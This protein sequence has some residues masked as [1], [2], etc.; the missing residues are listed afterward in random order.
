MS[1]STQGPTE[2]SSASPRTCRRAAA[3]L[4]PTAPIRSATSSSGAPASLGAFPTATVS[5]VSVRR[6]SLSNGILASPPASPPS[7]PRRPAAP[8]PRPGPRLHR[9]QQGGPGATK[10]GRHVG[11]RLGPLAY[12]PHPIREVQEH[13][14][15]RPKRAGRGPHRHAQA[16]HRL[17]GPARPPAPPPRPPPACAPP[18]PGPPPP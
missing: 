10:Q 2:I 16:G 18:P 7:P 8:R 4:D 11:S 9:R 3:A 17:P 15:G 13:F 6:D 5:A 12:A 14:L 1:E